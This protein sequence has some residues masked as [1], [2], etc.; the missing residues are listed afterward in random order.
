[1][2]TSTGRCDR[3]MIVRSLHG[4][5]SPWMCSYPTPR[6]AINMTYRIMIGISVTYIPDKKSIHCILYVQILK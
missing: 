1:M 4:R 3:V 2:N 6:L 5:I